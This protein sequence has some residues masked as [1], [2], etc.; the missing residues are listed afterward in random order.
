MKD[1]IEKVKANIILILAIMTLLFTICLIKYSDIFKQS[2]ITDVNTEIEMLGGKDTMSLQLQKLIPYDSVSD[3]KYKTAYQ[4]NKTNISSVHNNIILAAAKENLNKNNFT[5]KELIDQI[6]LNYGKNV[7]VSHNDFQFHIYEACE[8]KENSYTCQETDYDG[9]V[10]KALRNIT[11]LSINQE[12]Y[13]KEDILFISIETHETGLLY[14]IYEDGTYE[15]ITASFSDKDIEQT[16]VN[17]ENYLKQYE[18]KR[19]TYESK[20]IDNNNSYQW[21]STEKVL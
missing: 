20:F 10:Y 16:N 5:K 4:G 12:I 6:N 13:L 11:N 3:P 14:N 1:D 17:L 8:Y 9:I 7:F 2:A 21:I 19:V 18:D 15:H